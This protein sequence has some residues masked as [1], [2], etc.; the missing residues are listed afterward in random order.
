MCLWIL[1]LRKKMLGMPVL[2][3]SKHYMVLKINFTLYLRVSLCNKRW[4]F[5]NDLSRP[6]TKNLTKY[7]IFNEFP[8]QVDLFSWKSQIF[9]GDQFFLHKFTRLD[10]LHHNIL[11]PYFRGGFDS[12]SS[13]AGVSY[14]LK[15]WTHLIQNSH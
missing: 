11:S 9:L 15:C 3:S 8:R 1:T 12:G 6:F 5:E 4:E 13:V 10:I 14:E 2:I 7:E